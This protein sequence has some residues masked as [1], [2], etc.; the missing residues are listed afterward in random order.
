MGDL[1]FSTEKWGAVDGGRGEIKGMG[2][3]ARREGGEI[4]M[5]LENK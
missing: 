4:V 5:K 3:E 1:F 2:L